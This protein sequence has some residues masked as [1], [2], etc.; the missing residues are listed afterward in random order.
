MAKRKPFLLR[1]PEPL[2]DELSR[3]ARDDLRSLNAQIEFLLRD[4][5]RKRRNT[6]LA[7][8]SPEMQSEQHEP[9]AESRKPENL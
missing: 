5:V 9:S 7:D 1:L 3:W 6:T 2:L 4:V 8:P